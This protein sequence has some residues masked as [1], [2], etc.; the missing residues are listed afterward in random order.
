[1]G[2]SIPVILTAAIPLCR[3]L[4]AMSILRVAFELFLLY[5]LY[6]LVFDFII[7]VAKTTSQ[8][9]KQFRQMNENMQEQMNRQR[10]ANATAQPA[11]EPKKPAASDDYIEFE[12]IK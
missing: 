9:K 12:E 8:V 7:P 2:V 3:Y 4:C 6:K 11:A 5:L 1:L 10:Q